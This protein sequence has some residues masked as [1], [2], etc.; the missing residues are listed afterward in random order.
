MLYEDLKES[1]QER[2]GGQNHGKARTGKCLVFRI[3]PGTTCKYEYEGDGANIHT[4]MHL[5]PIRPLITRHHQA[6]INCSRPSLH[7]ETL[8]IISTHAQLT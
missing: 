4:F 1:K 2:S 7:L 6:S 3:K 5:E 8:S